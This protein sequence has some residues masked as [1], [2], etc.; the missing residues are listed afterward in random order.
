LRLVSIIRMKL[1]KTAQWILTLGILVALLV[2]VVT[3][4]GKQRAAQSDLNSELTRANQ[5]FV[6]YT[7][8]KGELQGRLS[9]ANSDLSQLNEKFHLLTESVEITGAIFK[10]ADDSNVDIGRIVS[11]PPANGGA[12][13]YDVFSLSINANGGVVALLKFCGKL[14]ETFPDSVINNVVIN[15]GA[16]GAATITLALTVYCYAGS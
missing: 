9:K 15:A 10:A 11:S 13:V 1:S 7:A 4:Y 16:G 3:V 8:Q 14:S 6:Q 12:G 5:N 2:G